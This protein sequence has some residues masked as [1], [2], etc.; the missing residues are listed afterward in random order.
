VKKT[1]AAALLGLVLAGCAPVGQAENLR[2]PATPVSEWRDDGAAAALARSMAEHLAAAH[3]VETNAAPP[4]ETTAADPAAPTTSADA[5]G[6][7]P[8]VIHRARIE[9]AREALVDDN[10]NK[11]RVDL[12]EELQRELAALQ[13]STEASKSRAHAGRSKKK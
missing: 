2:T 4:G 3:A 7:E 10:A 6:L 8:E 13:E 12:A 1:A 5:T 11:E 9:M